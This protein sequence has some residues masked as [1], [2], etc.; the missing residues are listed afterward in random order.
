M[1]CPWL[2]LHGSW[3]SWRLLAVVYGIARWKSRSVSWYIAAPSPAL[4]WRSWSLALNSSYAYLA[5]MIKIV[6]PL[7]FSPLVR[8][9]LQ[10]S[11]MS[12]TVPDVHHT[13]WSTRNTFGFGTLSLSLPKRSSVRTGLPIADIQIHRPENVVQGIFRTETLRGVECFAAAQWWENVNTKPQTQL[14]K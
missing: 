7:Y 11:A 12:A 4:L 1:L 10:L 2:K 5:K 13:M 3:F 14:K 6:A 9:A 8:H